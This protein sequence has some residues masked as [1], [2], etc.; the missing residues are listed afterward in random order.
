MADFGE[1]LTTSGLIVDHNIT[2]LT[3]HS[4][5]DFGY[6]M[7]SIML[8]ELP[9][10][11][12]QFFQ[13]HRQLFPCSYDLKMLLKHPGLVNA[14]LRGGLQEVRF[15]SGFILPCLQFSPFCP[16]GGGVFIELQWHQ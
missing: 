2:W 15:F 4:G 14:K 16:W 13:F 8:S 10:E 9:K 1:L 12:S 11:E 7:R 6:L 5:Y 3:F